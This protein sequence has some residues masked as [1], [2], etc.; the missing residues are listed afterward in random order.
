MR[1]PRR[2]ATVSVSQA[3]QG[4]EDAKA[5]LVAV[6]RQRS[7]GKARADDVKKAEEDLEKATRLQDTIEACAER[8]YCANDV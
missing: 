1:W 5:A 6:K 8:V 4:V 2:S 7:D 3:D